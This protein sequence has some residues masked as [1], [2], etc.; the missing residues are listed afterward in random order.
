MNIRSHKHLAIVTFAATLFV[1]NTSAVFAQSANQPA[2]NHAK[3]HELS[4][5]EFDKVLEH[6]EKLLIVDVRR[7][8][9]ISKIGGFPAY[10]SIQP[11]DLESHLKWIPRDRNIVTVSNHAARSGR[12]ADLLKSKGFKVLGTVGAKTYEEAGGNLSKI[13]PPQPGNNA[14]APKT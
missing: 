7:P 10:L 14:Q 11:A 8:D 3:S 2:A 12:A 5:A 13:V 1:A 4:R 6:P 9:E